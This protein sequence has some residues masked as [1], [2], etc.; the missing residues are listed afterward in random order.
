MHLLQCKTDFF[1]Y[2]HFWG[3]H[4]LQIKEHPSWEA[5]INIT[6]GSL[7]CLHSSTLAYTRLVTRLNSSA[8]VYTRLVTHLHSSTFVYTRLHLSAVV[9]W[10]V[11]TRLHSSTLVC[12]QFPDWHFPDGNFPDGH[13]PERT[14]SRRT[15][16]QLDISP[17]R[18]FPEWSFP[19]PDISLTTCFSEIFFFKS[20]FVC[21]Y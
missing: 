3:R 10:L 16:P 18:H 20:F 21:L 7:V 15:L 1:I 8:F 6:K 12:E 13:F 9:Y 14:I 11:Y 2:L 5:S 19:W 17:L 4:L